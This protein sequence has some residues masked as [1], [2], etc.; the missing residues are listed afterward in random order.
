[1][2][3]LDVGISTL[4]AFRFGVIFYKR[5][6]ATVLAMIGVCDRERYID[7]D[8]TGREPVVLRFIDS[9]E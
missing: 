5:S 8:A 9:C 1:M 6:S 7:T 3:I 2:I 4:R